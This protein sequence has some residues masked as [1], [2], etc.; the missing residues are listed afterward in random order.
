MS[1]SERAKKTYE[2]QIERM[3]KAREEK[4]R[5]KEMTE[6]GIPKSTRQSM[7]QTS[8]MT[9]QEDS[10]VVDQGDS[11]LLLSLDEKVKQSFD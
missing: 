4:N 10:G 6:R 2:K 3:N 9:G 11:G 1:A 8:M 7:A 5:V